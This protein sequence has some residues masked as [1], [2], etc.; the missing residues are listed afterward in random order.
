MAKVGD[1][2]E[3]TFS[4]D[5]VEQTMKLTKIV[6]IPP[7]C[8]IQVHGIMRVKGHDKRVDIIVEIKNNGYNPLVIAVLS[9]MCLKPGFSKINM[10]LRNLN[11]KSIMIKE[12]AMVA[13]L[14]VANAVPLCWHLRILKSQRRMKIKNRIPRYGF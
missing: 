13:Q 14:A 2:S 11:S 6:E 4:L 12:K 3:K 1:I 5:K 7:F 10:S 9:Y 8:I